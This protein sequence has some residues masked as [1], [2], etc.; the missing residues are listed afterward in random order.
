MKLG[1]KF[2]A[3]GTAAIATVL[4]SAGGAQAQDGG[5]LGLLGNTSPF[6]ISHSMRQAEMGG[7][8]GAQANNT[9]NNTNNNNNAGG[10]NNNNNNNNNNG[11]GTNNN[12]NNNNNAGGAQAQDGGLLGL[13]GITKLFNFQ[14]CHPVGQGGK[15]NTFSGNQN[16][17]CV[18]G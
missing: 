13:L 1:K 17:N 18:Q 8:D 11:G 2:A 9:N 14:V 6:P 5:L 4:F 15:G 16:V 7:D 3:I 10:V 12:N